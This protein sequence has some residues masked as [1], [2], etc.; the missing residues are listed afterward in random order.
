VVFV[1]DL[2]FGQGRAVVNAPV[3]RLQSFIYVAAVEKLDEGAGDDRF[4]VRAH[5]EIGLVPPA[6][7]A[8]TDKILTLKIHVFF[9]IFAAGFA[10]LGG[11]QGGLFGAQL[12][13]DAALDGQSVA[14][15]AGDVG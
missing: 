13:I 9:G 3:D 12:L 10:D 14:V 11:R 15:P 2:G 4:V 1:L 8:Q 5:S 6:E 7:H